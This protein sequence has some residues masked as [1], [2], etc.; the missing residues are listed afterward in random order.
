MNDEWKRCLPHY[1][2]AWEK[3]CTEYERRDPYI[4]ER[5]AGAHN[6]CYTRFNSVNST[7]PLWMDLDADSKP[8]PKTSGQS[9]TTGGSLP[10]LAQALSTMSPWK[11]ATT[12][13]RPER[14]RSPGK[15]KAKRINSRFA[16]AKGAAARVVVPRRCGPG[17][18]VPRRC[19]STARLWIS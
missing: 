2:D 4:R 16:L 5:P 9:A 15:A 7:V 3:Y 19:G 10:S 13:S 14:S 18:V 8:V 17:G 11:A 1:W 6:E 12:G